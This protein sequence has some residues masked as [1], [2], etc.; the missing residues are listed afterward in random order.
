MGN[1]ISLM[2]A[3]LITVSSMTIVFIALY[4]ICIVLQLFKVLFY[5]EGQVN[6]S[7]SKK[8]AAASSNDEIDEEE[9]LI[10]ALAAS[11]MAG[12]EKPNSRFHIKNITRIK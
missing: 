5:K 3:L 7:S 9:K 6:S 2:E 10:V 4:G 8:A 11:A 12:A 1:E